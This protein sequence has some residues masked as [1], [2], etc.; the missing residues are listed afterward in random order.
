MA[1]SAE[2]PAGMGWLPRS[3]EF[4]L[5]LLLF[6][7]ATMHYKYAEYIASVLEP[8]W[9]PWRPFWA[10]FTGAAM[11]AAAVS[12]VLHRQTRLAAIL[13]TALFFLYVAII[14]APSLAQNILHQPQDA[15]VLWAFNGTG[16]I[17]NALK[18]FALTL[19]A[20]FV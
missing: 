16:G 19:S 17:N 3:G 9:L 18:D 7:S 2:Q 1:T 5:A 6:Y 12:F 4:L 15:A 14:H 20:V 10:Y 8:S 11:L 13:L